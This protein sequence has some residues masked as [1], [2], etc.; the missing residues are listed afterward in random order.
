MERNPSADRCIEKQ[1]ENRHFQRRLLFNYLLASALFLIL[2]CFVFFVI[3]IIIIIN[4]VI[5]INFCFL[6]CLV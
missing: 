5:I 4:I 2:F 3:V 6:F 1:R